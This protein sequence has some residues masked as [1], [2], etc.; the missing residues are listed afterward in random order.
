MNLL[1]VNN[2]YYAIKDS[3]TKVNAA[4]IGNP[5]ISNDFIASN[6][7]DNNYLLLPGNFSPEN[8]TWEFRTKI[9]IASLPSSAYNAQT[10]ITRYTET[11]NFQLVL[12]RYGCFQLSLSSNGSSNDMLNSQYDSTKTFNINT[13]YYLSLS[14]DGSAYVFSYSTDNINF[15][16][17][18]RYTSSTPVYSGAQL[19]M[20][21]NYYTQTGYTPEHEP[22]TGGQI[23]MNETYIKIN[24]VITWYGTKQADIYHCIHTVDVLYAP[25]LDGTETIF[26]FTNSSYTPII[27]N[28]MLENGS[29]YLTEG[30]DNSVLWKCSF[31]AESTST[32]GNGWLLTLDNVTTRD[33]NEFL[34]VSG[35][36]LYMYE[37]GSTTLDSQ[38]GYTLYNTWRNIVVE[39]TS[40]TKIKLTMDGNYVATYTWNKL[41]TSSKVYIGVDKWNTNGYTKI[42]DILVVTV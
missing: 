30:W 42:K 19:R 26:T 24:N 2:K 8:N 39:K 33:S 20:G 40:A 38:T 12:N 21:N 13:W 14:F 37:D 23:D 31:T 36:R 27:S 4:S 35:G 6:F 1:K 15:T 32:S 28:N 29:G 34:Q 10:I 11:R 41:A 22:F 3:G 16:E 7:S 5:S 17:A 18:Y 25:A 9:K